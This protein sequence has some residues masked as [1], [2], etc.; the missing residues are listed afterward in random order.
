MHTVFPGQITRASAFYSVT[1]P[2]LLVWLLN[3]I[4]HNP[5]YSLTIILPH[6]SLVADESVAHG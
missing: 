6:T 2:R 5:Y 4:L 3:T 1:N